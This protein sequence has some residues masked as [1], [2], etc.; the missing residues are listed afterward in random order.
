MANPILPRNPENGQDSK[1]S[2]SALPR[3]STIAPSEKHLEDWIVN[4]IEL[5]AEDARLQV[6]RIVARQ[7]EFPSG[8]PDLILATVGSVAVVELK[9]YK[10]DGQAV[11]QVLRYLGDMRIVHDYHNEGEFTH[12]FNMHNYAISGRPIL[13]GVIVAAGFDNNAYLACINNNIDM[14]VYD[15]DGQDYSFDDADNDCGKSWTELR[16]TD[17][18]SA[19]LEL[20][21]HLNLYE[22]DRETLKAIYQREGVLL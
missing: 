1:A 12:H 22:R 20:I 3:H 5:F 9:K 14:L 7:P 21:R 4:N 8:R 13:H 19:I 10:A 18:E 11:A 16:G 6:R 17:T 2:E 15:F